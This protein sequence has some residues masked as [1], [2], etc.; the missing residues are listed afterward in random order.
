MEN[1]FRLEDIE[2]QE[3][4]IVNACDFREINWET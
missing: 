3:N 1:K 4:C 2:V